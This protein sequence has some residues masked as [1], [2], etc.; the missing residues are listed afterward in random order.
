[1][2]HKTYKTQ[3]WGIVKIRILNGITVKAAWRQED[4]IT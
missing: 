1:M 2:H 3:I 4:F